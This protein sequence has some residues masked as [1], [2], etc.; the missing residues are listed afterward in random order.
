MA[1]S[2]LVDAS[3]LVAFLR[4]RDANHSMLCLIQNPFGS[5]CCHFARMRASSSL[6]DRA[7]F[8]NV[9][10]RLK[11]MQA[12][13]TTRELRR[14]FS[15]SSHMGSSAEL[16]PPWMMSTCSRGSQRVHIAQITSLKLVGS[17][18]SSTTMVHRLQ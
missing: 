14:S 15:L 6:L 3:F 9:F 16:H 10:F 12:L 8:G 18:S 4:R 1:S 17:M 2:V 5:S 7:I 13:I 11:G